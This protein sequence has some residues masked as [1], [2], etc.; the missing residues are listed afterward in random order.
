MRTIACWCIVGVV[1][2]A[3]CSADDQRATADD[4]NGPDADSAEPPASGS[5]APA[6][7]AS[8]SSSSGAPV[9]TAG[10][11]ATSG[12]A[13]SGP[14]TSSPEPDQ[15]PDYPEQPPGVPFPT[16]SW[17]T[18]VLPSG[19][20]ATAIEAAVDLAFGAPD[21]EA[22][23]RSV[24]IVHAGRIVYE[25][26]HPLDGPDVAYSSFSVAKSYTSALIGLLVAD[27]TLALD[28]TSVRAEWSDPG[29]PRS[30][31]TVRDLLEMSSGLTWA[32]QYEADSMPL[33]MI[34]A[35]DAA[36]YVAS[37]PLEADPGSL[38]DYSTG[39]SA[40]LVGLAADELGGC[41][42]ATAYLGERLLD[43]IGIT[44]ETLLTDEG[45]CWL[46]GLGA[47]MTTRD[48]ARFGL[49]YLRGG[50]WDGEQ[51]LPT[52][53]IDETRVPAS[54]N[55]DYGLHWWLAD[56]GRSFSAEG[57]FGQRIVVVPDDDLVLAVNTTAGGDPGPLSATIL[58]QFAALGAD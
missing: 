16:R 56:D 31:I 53:W 6:S 40:L 39:T 28:D 12:P 38:Y 21:A 46:G 57:L 20:D 52:S 58:E 4:A 51:I 24:V 35:P 36:A 37:Q 44:T 49:L 26:Y 5:I 33:A 23:V 50:E 54:T 9:E 11:P 1:L 55:A 29:D 3:S 7:T 32:E 15:A 25:R 19:V 47:D 30:A 22:R 18:D 13:T 42:A 2:A 14:A 43:P 45:G 8:P 48:F 10:A 41:A 27:G 17:P 34:V